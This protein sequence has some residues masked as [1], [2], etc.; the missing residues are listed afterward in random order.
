MDGGEREIEFAPAMQGDAAID[1][2]GGKVGVEFDSL[3]EVGNRSIIATL[4]IPDEAAVAVD[5]GIGETES[6]CPIQVDERL[7]KCPFALPQDCPVMEY[8][9]VV[10]VNADRLLVVGE[11]TIEGAYFI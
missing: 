3:S 9:R 7:I 6:D 2:G 8:G 5:I 4:F 11:R 1:A 10:W